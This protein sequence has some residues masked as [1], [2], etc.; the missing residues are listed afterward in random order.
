MNPRSKA[1]KKM[2]LKY[3]K[4]SIPTEKLLL[5][6]N[7]PIERS[8]TELI[9]DFSFYFQINDWVEISDRKNTEQ[10]KDDTRQVLVEVR[11]SNGFISSLKSCRKLLKGKEGLSIIQGK[12]TKQNRTQKNHKVFIGNLPIS[13]RVLTI[14]LAQIFLQF[15][16]I[17]FIYPVK[18]MSNGLC[19]GFGFVGFK[20]A[21]S[22][23]KAVQV[24]KDGLYYLADKIFCDYKFQSNPDYSEYIQIKDVKDKKKFNQK[25]S[26]IQTDTIKKSPK[27]RKTVY[28]ADGAS[29]SKLR[30][31]N[32]HLNK[33]LEDQI[34]N[35]RFGPPIECPPFLLVEESGW[36]YY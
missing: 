26:F 23:Q 13:T 9:R 4:P 34:V 17:S 22:A 30:T 27:G 16:P 12:P 5:L 29:N 8:T 2:P 1:P 18:N 3:K 35:C 25:K 14:E 20:D 24:S 28:T 7:I 36:K 11:T 31:Q 21:Q 15:G 19:K 33:S 6:E 32:Y 10:P